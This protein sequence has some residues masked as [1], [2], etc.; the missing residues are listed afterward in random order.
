MPSIGPNSSAPDQTLALNDPGDDTA[1]RYRFQ[2]AWAANVCCSLFDDTQDIVEVFCEHHED[3][4]VKHRDGKFT[5]HQV[6]SRDTDQPLW[7]SGDEQ[8]IAACARF[9]QLDEGHPGQFRGFRLLTSHPL[10]VAE[11][12]RSIGYALAQVASAPTFADLPTDV[13]TWL[14]R[15]ARAAN[16][17]EMVAFQAL[18]KTTASDDLPKL[19]D[20][21]V[22]LIQTLT[23]CWPEAAECSHQSVTAAARALIDECARASALEHEQLLP[24]YLFAVHQ[25]Q[26]G[27]AARIVGKRMTLDRVRTVLAG[28]LTATATLTGHP[29]RRAEPGEGSS[30]LLLKKLDA[31]GFS[32]VSLNSAE[33]LRDKA[34]YLAIAWTKTLGKTKGLGRYEHVRSL[35]LSDAARAFEATKTDCQK[36]GPAMREDLRKRF[37]ERRANGEKLF[38]CRDEHLEGFAYSLTAQCKIQWST[39][40][41]WEVG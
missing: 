31:G 38:D 11:N 25:P 26:A 37:Q 22:R 4:L 9:V 39:D 2:Y 29:D 40:R 14:R 35:A 28:G 7:K 41:P 18:K 33:D 3:V 15:I 17:S 5:G 6:K 16:A 30:D 21:T 24:A 34:D 19:R 13:A 8:I 20:A 36:F 1:R 10:H 32:A 23:E 27:I 12:A